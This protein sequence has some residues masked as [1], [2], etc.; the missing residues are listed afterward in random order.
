VTRQTI[1]KMKT[2]MLNKTVFQGYN[3]A[4]KGYSYGLGVRTMTNPELHFAK[5]PVGEFGWDGAAG[6]YSLMDTDHELA[7]FY[8]QHVRKC[9]VSYD[10]IHPMLRDMTYMALGL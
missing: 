9:L 2:P 4:A 10:H 5:S 8:V 6:S 3:H 1:E 7:I